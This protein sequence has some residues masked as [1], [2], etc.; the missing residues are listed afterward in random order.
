MEEQ[1]KYQLYHQAKFTNMNDGE[2]IFTS[3]QQKIIEHARFTYSPLGKAFEKQMK[4]TDN[5]GKKQVDALKNLKPKEQTEA[6]GEK[7]NN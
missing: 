6:I 5:Q 3:N 7:S 4:I 2:D 1:P